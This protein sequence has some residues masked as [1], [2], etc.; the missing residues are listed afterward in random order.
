MKHCS[1][2]TDMQQRRDTKRRPYRHVPLSLLFACARLPPVVSLP[3]HEV[4]MLPPGLEGPALAAAYN[5][6]AQH[7]WLSKIHVCLSVPAS[8]NKHSFH[9]KKDGTSGPW[10]AHP[11]RLGLRFLDALQGLTCRIDISH[12]RCICACNA[13][14]SA[15]EQHAPTIQC[16]WVL[17]A[18]CRGTHQPS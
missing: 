17:G 13:T 14:C 10:S 4:L 3:P 1:F 2:M 9:A 5:C 15:R 18:G 6:D 11:V 16:C 8:A 7:G 12:R